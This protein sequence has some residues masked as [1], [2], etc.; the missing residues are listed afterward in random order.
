MSAVRKKASRRPTKERRETDNLVGADMTIDESANA[1][2]IP[3]KFKKSVRNVSN[4]VKQEVTKQEEE[5]VWDDTDENLLKDNMKGRRNRRSKCQN[6]NDEDEGVDYPSD[7]WFI[8]SE[9]IQPEAVGKFARIC[10][11]SYY[12]TTT[13]KFWFHLYKSYY[14][15]VPSLPERLQPQCQRLHGLR[16]CVIRALHYNYFRTSEGEGDDMSY[17]RQEEPH[18]LVKRKCI[19]MWHKEGKVRWYFYFKL[20]EVSKI[21]N[22]LL[23]Q[24]KQ[25]DVKKT[26]FL[27]T[28]EDVAVNP[29]DGCKVLRVSCLKYSMLPLVIG[30][31]L[32]TVSINLMPGFR[33]YRL[34]LGFGTSDVPSTLTNQIIL[35]NV[36]GYSILNWWDPAYPHQDVGYTIELPQN[37]SWEI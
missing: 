12:V 28:L 18:S 14:K 9:Y 32:Q 4:E 26:E 33:E 22:S 23:K 16:A 30:L 34:Q 1:L 6:N 5:L 10:K 8:I 35:R 20:K 17:L 7:I 11:S 24:N 37:D 19:L 25:Y 29:E 2:R 21:R 27:E 36:I 13:G 31:V 15:F 3:A